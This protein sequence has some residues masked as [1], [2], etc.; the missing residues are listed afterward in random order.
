MKFVPIFGDEK[1]PIYA[2]KYDGE[3]T[4]AFQRLMQEWRDVEFLYHF[5]SENEKDLQG[6][7]IEEA[8]EIVMDQVDDFEE[9]FLDI[10][11]TASRDQKKKLEKL[12]IPLNKVIS[13]Y[14]KPFPQKRHMGEKSGY[15]FMPCM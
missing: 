5:F 10:L 12:F 15:V 13:P 14:D 1:S 4:D 7:S 3:S 6:E 8:V 11:E 2:T 9:T